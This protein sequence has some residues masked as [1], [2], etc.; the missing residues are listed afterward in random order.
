MACLCH[1]QL[2]RFLNYYFELNLLCQLDIVTVLRLL[3]RYIHT[4]STLCASHQWT[5]LFTIR[6]AHTF[7][8]A[9]CH[10]PSASANIWAANSALVR[11]FLILFLVQQHGPERR[12]S[13]FPFLLLLAL[14]QPRVT[15]FAA[16]APLV[17]LAASDLVV[18]QISAPPCNS[19]V[20][21]W[22]WVISLC[23]RLW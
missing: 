17:L 7:E 22:E 4:F 5:Q 1:V 23:G 15:G 10:W 9:N 16:L 20:P 3:A 8:R 21:G 13:P 2:N 6:H 12:Q 18:A 14:M 11:D 19:S